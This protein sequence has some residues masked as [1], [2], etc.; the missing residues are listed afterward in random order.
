MP[1]F[2]LIQRDFCLNNI[3]VHIIEA[4]NLGIGWQIVEDKY[5]DTNIQNWLMGRPE[6]SALIHKLIEAL[7]NGI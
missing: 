6:A 4:K 2:I 5:N 7:K 1:K 3:K